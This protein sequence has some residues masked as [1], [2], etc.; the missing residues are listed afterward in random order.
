MK[1]L[2]TA[3]VALSVISC[4]SSP[5]SGPTRGVI[6]DYAEQL[7]AW[8]E[9]GISDYSFRFSRSCFC[10]IDLLRPVEI[11]VRGDTIASVTDVESGEPVDPSNVQFYRTIDGLFALIGEAIAGKAQVLDATYDPDLHYPTDV[12]IDMSAQ[13][14]D[15]EQGF[16]AAGLVPLHTIAASTFVNGVD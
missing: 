15:E 7:Q 8:E 3:L 13:I 10:P 4:S 16:T 9:L 1:A 5:P 14:A 2:V 6:T 11:V 12:Y